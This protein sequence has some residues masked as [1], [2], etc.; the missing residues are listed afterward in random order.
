MA[1]EATICWVDADDRVVEVGGGCESFT[2]ANEGEAAT[3][4]RVIGRPVWDFVSGDAPCVLLSTLLDWVRVH[5]RELR[6][7][8]RCDSPTERRFMEMIIAP[9]GDRVRLEHRVLRVEPIERPVA[10]RF[11]SS[12]RHHVRAACATPSASPARGAT[13][14]KPATMG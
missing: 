9:D 8:Y 10:P 4:S 11:S 14:P 13:R 12:G 2:A 3:G 5:G 1:D 6:R 7:A